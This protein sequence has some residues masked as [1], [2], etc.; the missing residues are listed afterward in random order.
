MCLQT[1]PRIPPYT[2]PSHPPQHHLPAQHQETERQ[3]PGS[4]DP[5]TALARTSRTNESPSLPLLSERLLRLLLYRRPAAQ[6]KAPMLKVREPS[7]AIRWKDSQSPRAP[8]SCC[9]PGYHRRSHIGALSRQHYPLL[10]GRCG[11]P[12]AAPSQLIRH[13]AE[14]AGLS[15]RGLG[16]TATSLHTNRE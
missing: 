11:L 16:T 8:G 9:V 1:C 10:I 5:V 3:L 7:E 6:R 13:T 4:Q 12:Q 15:W 14:V 2:P